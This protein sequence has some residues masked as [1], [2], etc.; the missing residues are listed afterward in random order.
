MHPAVWWLLYTIAGVWLQSWI[1]GVDVFAPA[2][3]VCLQE[4]RRREALWG[5]VCWTVLQ[6]GAGNMPFGSMILWYIALV[7]VVT[8]SRS[9]F[10]SR[11]IVFILCSG[12]MLGGL[13][14]FMT[15]GMSALQGLSV[16][17]HRVLLESAAQPVV[18]VLVWWITYTLYTRLV[19]HETVL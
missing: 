7:L 17:T 10:D 5:I 19:H 4:E 2:V 12:I 13:H 15:L 9:L 16:D 11:N 3:M 8:V 1:P 14:Y 18:F 6:E